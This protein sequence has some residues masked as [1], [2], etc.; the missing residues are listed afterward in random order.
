MDHE[1][2]YEEL[3]TARQMDQL[4][5]ET[6]KEVGL[7]DDGEFGVE[8]TPE[9]LGVARMR[10]LVKTQEESLRHEGARKFDPEL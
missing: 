6:A 10:D 7:Q 3:R 9:E 2:D 8:I 1:K 5:R 4:E